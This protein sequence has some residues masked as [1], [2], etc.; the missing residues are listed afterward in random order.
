M[1]GNKALIYKSIPNG[2]PVAGK[3]LVVEEVA[4][5]DASAPAPEGG[6]QLQNLYGSYDPYL[7]QRMRS[8]EVEAIALPFELNKPIDNTHIAKVLKSNHPDFKEGDLVLSFLPFQQFIKVTPSEIKAWGL[9]RI[10]NPLG[11]DIRHFLGIL[12]MPGLTAYSSFYEICKPKKGETILVS[13]ASGAVGQV[14]GSLAKR[15]GLK[16]IGSVGSDAKL[17]YIINELGF[18][19]G[20]NYKKEKPG[21]AIKRL[22]PEG[23]D[24]YYENVGGE[25]FEAALNNMKTWGRIAVCGLISQYNKPP[26]EH[27][28]I[29]NI[30]EILNRRLIIRGFVVGDPDFE[31]YRKEHQERVQKWL[32]EGSIKEKIWEADGIDKAAEGFV[33]LFTGE[34]FGKA[35]LKY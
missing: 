17:D 4:D 31:A 7:R 23:L 29:R 13:A 21:D 11:L 28:P 20:F 30:W 3:D 5:Y 12:G 26:E 33:A 14:V 25:H 9:T 8:P 18:D 16:V 27:Y 32:K 6:L 35:V 24:I 19:G 34:N 15:E 2:L 10:E 1:P 22:A